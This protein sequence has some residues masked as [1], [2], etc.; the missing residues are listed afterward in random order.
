MKQWKKYVG[1]DKP[2]FQSY[3]YYANQTPKESMKGKEKPGPITNSDILEDPANYYTSDDPD[4]MYN[5][6][7]KPEQR[8]RLDYKILTDKQWEFLYSRYGG[9]P[10]KREKY[11]AEYYAHYQVE[12]YFQ[13]INLSILP[14]RSEFDSTKII[15]PKP[16]YAGKRWSLTQLR[17]RLVKV[18]NSP[19]YSLKL[20]VSKIRLWKMDPTTSYEDFIGK[21]ALFGSKIKNSPITNVEGANI[22]ENTGIEF[23]GMSLDLFATKTI[24]KCNIGEYDKIILEQANDKGEFIFKYLKSAKIGRCDFCYTDKP[25]I[26]AC[27]C[28]EVFYCSESCKKKDERFHAEKCTAVDLTADLSQ[29]KQSTKSNMGLTGLQNLGNTCFMNS[30]LQCLSNTWELT[31]FFLEDK[32]MAEIN[33]TNKLGTQG[34]VAISFAKL[35]KLLWYDNSPFVSPWDLKKAI[36]GYHH[37]FSGFAQQDAQELISSVLDALHEDLNR[38]Q[39]KPYIESK[40]TDSPTDDTI[41]TECWYHHLARNQSIIVDLMHGQFKSIVNCPDCGRYSVAFDPF[42]VVSLPLPQE[43]VVSITFYYVPYD[44]AKPIQKCVINIDKEETVKTLREKISE[45]LGIHKDSTILT[46]ISANTFDRFF[47]RERKVKLIHKLASKRNSIMYAFEINPAFFNGP[48]NQGIDEKEEIEKHRKELAAEDKKDEILNKNQEEEKQ[49]G[50]KHSQNWG[51]QSDFMY[52]KKKKVD[53]ICD[54]DDYN[55]GLVDDVIKVYFH[56]FQESKYSY[57]GG[58]KKERVSFNRLIFAKRSW[59][60]KQLHLEVFKYLRPLFEKGL[61]KQNKPE[62]MTDNA[63]DLADDAKIASK[64]EKL[65]DIEMFEKLFPG[66]SEETWEFK[67]KEISG[68]PYILRLQNFHS[69]SYSSKENCVYCGKWDCKNCPV[70]YTDSLRVSDLL[71]KINNKDIIRNDYYYKE[72]AQY[73]A[74]K[75]EFELEVTFS[76]EK[77]QAIAALDNIDKIELHPKYSEILGGKDQAVSINDCFEL[78]SRTETLDEQ[79]LW[80]CNK[81]KNSVRAKKKM[82]IFKCPPILILHLKRFR[83]R[84]S[85]IL[86]SAGRINVL[87]DFPLEGLDLSKYVKVSNGHKPIYD[88]YAVSNH[89]GNTGFGHY[90]AFAF[91]HHAKDWY[92]FDDSSVSKLDKLEVCSTAAYVL[93]YK[94]RDFIDEIDYEKIKQKLPPDF[95]VP[96]ITPSKPKPKENKSDTDTVSSVKSN[97]EMK[98]I[99]PPSIS[100]LTLPSIGNNGHNINNQY[101]QNAQ[102][103]QNRQNAQNSQNNAFQSQN[104]NNSV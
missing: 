36:G 97:E 51:Y 2:K 26:V 41:S 39:V 94:R 92:R 1:L 61:L 88:L 8:E 21:L 77:D 49:I 75:Q 40:T 10:I 42:S 20:N 70:P 29:Y 93:F 60:L 69:Q 45:L 15:P 13:K 74:G 91:N 47:C 68:Y 62:P 71:S 34:K 76:G 44:L 52:G 30:G 56:I 87:I 53:D 12:V 80:Y 37:T 48:E 46:S 17:E 83:V 65:S 63:M 23:P 96:E 57:M 103:N 11:K 59:T 18:L 95:K 54:H 7:L 25:L 16:I 67:L 82:E 101:S 3:P 31:R 66:L 43:S 58:S 50:Q 35:V 84:E 99:T 55:N 32:Y 24:E 104:S 64:T 90:T 98:D 19:K 79:N 9:V 81:C 5:V 100:A 22:E 27:K 14:D 4:D 86:G 28:N 6:V 73:N 102:N 89:Y 85:G 72:H 33:K 38:V 78:F